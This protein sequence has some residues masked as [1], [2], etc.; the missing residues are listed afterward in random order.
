MREGSHQGKIRIY[1]WQKHH[2]IIKIKI[3]NAF[4]EKFSFSSKT[5]SIGSY[6]KTVDTGN[7][8]TQLVIRQS[9][10]PDVFRTRVVDGSLVMSSD[11]VLR[12]TRDNNPSF[13]SQMRVMTFACKYSIDK[14]TSE[15]F[16][17]THWP[18]ETLVENNKVCVIIFFTIQTAF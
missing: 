5:Y 3:T 16:N 2:K 13:S 11:V 9:E 6:S 14:E 17:P 18:S 15:V 7:T 10:N 8:E 1:L 4:H 12:L